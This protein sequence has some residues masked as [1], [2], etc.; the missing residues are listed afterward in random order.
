MTVGEFPHTPYPAQVRAMSR[1]RH[2]SFSRFPNGLGLQDFGQKS[3]FYQ[4]KW[5]LT[6]FNVALQRWQCFIYENDGWTTNFLKNHDPGQSVSRYGS[7]DPHFAATS[8]DRQD[9]GC[10]Y[11][12]SDSS[13]DK[14]SVS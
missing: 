6:E 9:T 5:A 7:D 12:Y 11:H 4:R 3:K 14:R 1:T 8:A 2:V 13:W 10:I